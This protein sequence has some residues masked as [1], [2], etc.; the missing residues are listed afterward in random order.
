LDIPVDVDQRE[1]DQLSGQIIVVKCGGN[2]MV[3]DRVKQNIVEDIVALKEVGAIPV[4]VHGGGPMIQKLLDEVGIQSEFIDG[5]RKTDEQTMEYVEMAL[6]GSVNSEL[7]SLISRKGYRAVGLSGKDGNLATAR[8]RIHEVTIDG[9]TQQTDLGHVGDIDS[10]D[11]SLIQLLIDNDYIPVVSPVAGGEELDA[12]NV[13]ADMFAGHLAGALEA[14]SYVAL[15]NVDGLQLDPK[16]PSTLISEITVSQARS[17]IGQAIEGGMIPKVESCIIALEE[18]AR[19]ARI[20]NG[21]K[22]HTILKALLTTETVG[23]LLTDEET[24]E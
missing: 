10:I 1:A 23:T 11:T 18:G 16:D 6:T 9:K 14:A 13:N 2:A 21:M 5:H 15:T 8:K 20:L 3:D 19:S 4:I 17:Q 22:E 24:D 7:V 12:Y